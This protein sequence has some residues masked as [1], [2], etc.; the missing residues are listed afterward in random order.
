MDIK[1]LKN[2]LYLNPE[3]IQLILESLGCHHIKLHKGSGMD[4]SYYTFGNPDGNNI[5]ACT[6]Y[7]SE[8][9]LTINYTRPEFSSKKKN[10]DFLDLVHFYQ[11]DKNFFQVL[12]WV[13]EQSDL[14]YYQDLNDEVPYL[15]KVLEKINS[16][17]NQVV[18]KEEK[19]IKQIPEK[20]LTYYDKHVSEMFYEDGVD[21][22]TQLEFEVG[23]DTSTNRWTMPYRDEIGN[24]I[25]VKGRYFYREVPENEEKFY[26]MEP[27]PR[28]RVLYGYYKTHKH[29]QESDYVLVHESEK[30]TWQS[31]AYGYKNCVSTGGTRLSSVQIEKI[32]RLNKK[33]ILSFDRDFT[34]EAIQILRNKFISQIDFWAIIDKEGILGDKESPTDKKDKFEY[35][36]KNHVYKINKT[37]D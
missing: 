7:V 15:L 6:V 23:F 22:L 36:L 32:S 10:G 28:G 35:L 13:A 34:E 4:D 8:N 30:A 27:C 33:V 11:Q 29:I 37:E 16:A 26:Y 25:G 31:W 9:L 14:D 2:H 5:S 24:L 20:I 1:K 3:K 18:E 12:K 17:R 19:P 21:Y